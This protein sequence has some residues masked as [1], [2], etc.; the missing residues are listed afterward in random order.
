MEFDMNAG[1]RGE[2]LDSLPM[3]EKNV[4]YTKERYNF[5]LSMAI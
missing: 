2:L 5:H 1:W 4:I 3:R